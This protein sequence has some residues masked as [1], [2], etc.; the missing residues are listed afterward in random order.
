MFVIADI[1]GA[2]PIPQLH[3]TVRRHT[4]GHPRTMPNGTMIRFERVTPR[5]LESLVTPRGPISILTNMTMWYILV[6]KKAPVLGTQRKNQ[7][8]NIIALEV[9]DYGF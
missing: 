4:L 1:N 5:Q 6:R 3:A 9:L 7:I 2:Y 8:N